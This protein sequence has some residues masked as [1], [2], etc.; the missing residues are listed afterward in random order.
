[1]KN[2]LTQMTTTSSGTPK[3]AHYLQFLDSWRSGDYTS[4]F[5]S[6]HRYF[7]YTMQARDRI[8]YQY[9]LL[10]LAILQADFGNHTEAI[11]AIQEAIATARENRDATCLNY[12]MSWL[13]HFARA[14][15]STANNASLKALRETG[16]LGNEV[17]GLAFLKSRAKEAEMWTLLSTSLLSEAK[18]SLQHG[19]SL[20]YVLENITKATHVN[21]VKSIQNCT[22]PAVLLK[23]T[24]FSRIGQTHMAYS[25]G[26]RF[27]T[28]HVSS[29]P[30][31]STR[32]N[33]VAPLE[34]ALKCTLRTSALLAQSGHLNKS[35]HLLTSLPTTHRNVMGV[36]KHKTYY[37][38]HMQ[39]A[40]V[41]RLLHRN[42]LVSASKIV[43]TL[44]SQTPHPDTETSFQIALLEIDLLTRQRNFTDALIAIEALANRVV[45][46]N[47]DVLWKSKLMALKA[48]LWT[49]GDKPLKGFSLTIRAID[50]A[51]KARVLPVLFEAVTVLGTILNESYE[52]K[53]AA[54]LLL[55]ILPG[56]LECQDCDLAGRLYLVLADS[57]VGLAGLAGNEDTAAE[58]KRKRK[59][60][61]G[62]AME[63][64]EKALEQ[65]GG[66][67]E[68]EGQL[69]CLG[70]MGRI[71]MFRGDAKSA[72][73]L[74]ER[75]AKLRTQYGEE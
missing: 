73:E 63:Y 5:D 52:F 59:E 74:G 46:E 21:M 53:A 58:T 69:E 7:D 12:C 8:F 67:E 72:G 70:K 71:C 1:M 50:T 2:R 11:P 47:N 31:H 38:T 68:V 34:D 4:A 54:D 55:A 56:T 65:F 44:R 16:I 45:S 48:G 29:S 10:N 36:L 43:S 41:R 61:M 25:G 39:I 13:Y 26:E 24:L 18:L 17:E 27:L 3:L 64:L 37:K 9:A 28:C 49:K 32:S 57:W 42:Q 75:Y 60:F 15:P 66:V 62:T 35:H 14:F 19:D 30:A 20:A 6:L 40:W 33:D 23:S 22:G 51:Y